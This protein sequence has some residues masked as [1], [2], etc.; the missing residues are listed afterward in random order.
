MTYSSENYTKYT[1]P[2]PVYQLTV[3]RFLHRLSALVCQVQP[4]SILEIG[5]GE[6]FVLDYLVKRHPELSY[7]GVD[8][9]AEAVRMARRITAPGIDYICADGREIPLPDKQFDLVIVSE[10]L[11]HVARPDQVLAEALRLSN[12]HVLVTVPLEPHFQRVSDLLV[13]L[14]LG[15]RPGHVNF[16]TAAEL[17][18]WLSRQLH[19]AHYEICDLYQL[20]LCQA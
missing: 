11:E 5:C 7:T 2:N 18:R 9:S 1:H 15:H 19:V 10:V 13:W 4:Q 3:F 16:W 8:L 12:P 17:R 6:G 14:K 20:A